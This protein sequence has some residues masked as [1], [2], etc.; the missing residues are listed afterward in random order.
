MSAS[1]MP[2]FGGQPSITTPMPPPCDSPKVVTRK[3]CPSVLPIA[4]IVAQ[5]SCLWGQLASRLLDRGSA[6]ETPAC[7]TAERRLCYIAS[8]ANSRSLI[9]IRRVSRV[10]DRELAQAAATAAAR[11]R[12]ERWKLSSAHEQENDPERDLKTRYRAGG[13]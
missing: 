5:A 12:T 2:I 8:K 3:S 10:C 13:F 4:R 7:P 1:E 9:E 11:A 6:G